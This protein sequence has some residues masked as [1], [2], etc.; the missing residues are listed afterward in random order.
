MLLVTLLDMLS[1]LTRL[2]IMRYRSLL[3]FLFKLVRRCYLCEATIHFPYNFLPTHL[4]VTFA[5]YAVLI[6]AYKSTDSYSYPCEK[7]A[8]DL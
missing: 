4:P 7:Y 5:V 2:L 3:T 6:S 8:N 1:T